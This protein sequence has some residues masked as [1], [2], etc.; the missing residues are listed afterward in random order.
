MLDNIYKLISF[1]IGFM[2]SLLFKRVCECRNC[3]IFK[4]PNPAKIKDNIYI[5]EDKCFKFETENT[6]CTSSAIK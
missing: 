1:I 3:I 6:T 5:E 2:I 4:A